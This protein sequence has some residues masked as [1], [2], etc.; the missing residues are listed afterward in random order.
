M[1]YD[2]LLRLL[3]HLVEKAFKELGRPGAWTPDAAVSG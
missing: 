1:A 2:K 3:V